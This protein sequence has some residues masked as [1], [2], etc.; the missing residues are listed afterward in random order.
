MARLIGP[1]NGQRLVYVLSG[2]LLRSAAGYTAV[3]YSD[4]AGTVLADIAAY[5]PLNPTVPGSVIAGSTLQVDSTSRLPLFWFPLN[6]QDT[7]YVRVGGTSSPLVSIN[8]DYDSRIDGLVV[9]SGVTSVNGDTGPIVVL[10]AADVGADP[11][12]AATTAVAAHEA[13]TTNVHGIANTAVLATSTDVSNAV[14]AALADTTAVHGIS[15]TS[16][17]VFGPA[18]ST[19]NAIARFDLATGK[20][21]QNSL[22]TVSDAGLINAV[23][24]T[25]TNDVTILGTG[26]GYR[27]RASGGNLDFDATGA[28]M[29]L[30]VFTGTTFDGTQRTY[31]RFESG[32]E[33]THIAGRVESCTSVFG[34]S[35]HALDPVT[36]VAELGAKNSL[37]NVRISGRRATT[38]APTTGTWAAGDT[39]QDSAG[40][41]WL[42]TVGGTPGTWVGGS[43]GSV[44]TRSGYV[45]AGDQTLTNVGATWTAVPGLTGFTIPAVVGDRI[46]I[47]LSFLARMLGTNF[48]D[49]V[50]TVGGVIQRSASNGTA[51]PA[52][53]GDPTLYRDAADNTTRGAGPFFFTAVSGDLSGGNVTFG[54]FF[55]GTGTTSI[56]YN[57]A[58]YPFRYLAKN[59]GQ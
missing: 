41:W 44:V 29:F 50:V 12:G 3:F 52:V 8:A 23:G 1:D 21:I 20:L 11:A 53:E 30:S 2:S 27:M 49:T 42:C 13:D 24:L 43:G 54:L 47:Q 10:D 6:G 16:L 34:G 25:S 17:L 14:A 5:Q 22:A 32:V 46:E 36:G 15:D 57:S 19:D 45:T 18:S 48:L 28:S 59:Y 33:L 38:G 9:G 35:V 40:A 56:V 26:K 4:V 7:L 37:A 58:N 51:T 31:L 55:K 39:V